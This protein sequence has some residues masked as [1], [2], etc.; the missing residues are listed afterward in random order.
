[1]A[2]IYLVLQGSTGFLAAADPARPVQSWAVLIIAL[3]LIL[4]MTY[5]FFTAV[6]ML[7]AV[8]KYQ[9]L[10][11]QHGRLFLAMIG[12]TF[13][14][15]AFITPVML[16]ALA[17]VALTYLF[18]PKLDL[19]AQASFPNSFT[20]IF[21]ETLI[22]SVLETLLIYFLLNAADLAVGR[23]ARQANAKAVLSPPQADWLNGRQTSRQQSARQPPGR[24]PP[25]HSQRNFPW[26]LVVLLI[27]VLAASAILSFSMR[28]GA[29]SEYNQQIMILTGKG[30]LALE[31]GQT[32]LAAINHRKAYSMILAAEGYLKGLSEAPELAAASAADLTRALE[33]DRG[34][35]WV[36]IFRGFLANRAKDF[37]A[38]Q[39]Q[40]A[41]A[42]AGEQVLPDIYFG[43]LSCYRGLDDQKNANRMIEL[44]IKHQFNRGSL[45]AAANLSENAL[46]EELEFLEKMRDQEYDYLVLGALEKLK[47]NDAQG[48]FED[49]RRLLE[50]DPDNETLLYYY[51]VASMSWRPE[52][53]N[54]GIANAT[55]DRLLALSDDED[56]AKYL[57][58]YMSLLTKDY[59]A[60]VDKLAA[61]YRK[62][63][64]S[65]GFGEQYAFALLL[66]GQNDQAAEVTSKVL[67]QDA[68]SWF[69]HYINALVALKSGG[70]PN[71]WR[72]WK[73][74]WLL[75]AAWS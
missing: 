7:A 62:Y 33:Y 49:I 23:Y 2:A 31:L 55:F 10:F 59:A 27:F 67:K 75:P 60:A 57:K 54:Y 6:M 35:I 28:P 34:N 41:I 26:L 5:L 22:V 72:R 3:I 58:G 24:Q 50:S 65:A 32:D 69:C 66:S 44:L 61:I 11:R 47:Y 14:Q 15:V 37:T 43:A 40:F 56:G 38:A 19:Y 42:L 16:T 12:A 68:E 53:A 25:V 21:L 52:T 73:K 39:A 18:L 74:S 51:G 45:D 64:G 46:Q 8:F 9:I 30:D 17:L 13:R 1:M 71:R 36:Y 29:L 70:L 48:M 20:W 4:A 63:P